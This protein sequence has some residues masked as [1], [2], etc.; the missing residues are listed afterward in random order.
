MNKKKQTNLVTFSWLPE[1]KKNIDK[2]FIEWFI[3]FSEGDGSF[4]A[5]PYKNKLDVVQ[6]FYRHSFIINQK[7]PQVLFNLRTTLGFGQVKQY[8]N[9]KQGTSYFRYVVSDL[10]GIE[11]LIHIFNGNLV[12]DKT[13]ER[14]KIWLDTY[15]Q[16]PKIINPVIPLPHVGNNLSLS[17]AW[18]SGFIDAEGCLNS[19]CSL[20]PLNNKLSVHLRFIID[21]KNESQ[22]LNKINQ[23]FRTG[24]VQIRL[25]CAT[26]ERFVLEFKKIIQI[27]SVNSKK[28]YNNMEKIEDFNLMFK[29]LESFP[30]RTQKNIKLVRFKKIWIRLND[31]MLRPITS[32]SY[33]RLLRLINSLNT[34]IITQAE[35]D[36]VNF[37][38]TSEID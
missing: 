11:R 18:L 35:K 15:N 36:I 30:L 27:N 3:G 29:Y 14:F 37:K 20:D 19:S 16:R 22:I 5:T 26:M 10:E 23:F 24:S 9:T 13:Q 32:K 17:S 31:T 12:L 25:E 2:H 8:H 33:E 34:E 4:S 38:D 21:Q 6:P 7:E 28:V 1:H